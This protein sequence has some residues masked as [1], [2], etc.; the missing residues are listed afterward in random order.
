MGIL[1]LDPFS[2]CHWYI[3]KSSPFGPTEWKAVSQAFWI[4][5]LFCLRTLRGTRSWPKWNGSRIFA[6]RSCLNSVFGEKCSSFA[7]NG[8]KTPTNET[9]GLEVHQVTPKLEAGRKA[10]QKLQA[11]RRLVTILKC[12]LISSLLLSLN[13]CTLFIYSFF[14]EFPYQLWV[15][16]SPFNSPSP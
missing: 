8:T 9:H 7:L 11:E 14:L 12:S 6:Q 15:L 13:K 2:L 5:L 1:L 4:P 3:F 16:P 10:S